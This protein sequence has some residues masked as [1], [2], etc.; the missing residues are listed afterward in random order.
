MLS[1]CT[2]MLQ[3]INNTQRLHEKC[4]NLLYKKFKFSVIGHPATFNVSV[5]SAPDFPVDIYFLVDGSFSM[6]DDLANI[7]QLGGAIGMAENLSEFLTFSAEE[8][9]EPC[10]TSMM[11]D[12][13]KN[14]QRLLIVS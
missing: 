6:A 14:N 13:C 12:F 3:S 10:K 8:Y 2:L 11:E 9:L 7:R 1:S 5:K 4:S